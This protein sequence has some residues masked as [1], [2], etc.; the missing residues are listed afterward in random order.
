MWRV[1]FPQIWTLD[2]ILQVG[3]MKD[4]E[5]GKVEILE[6]DAGGVLTCRCVQGG[7][8]GRDK[9]EGATVIQARCGAGWGSR[10]KLTCPV[11]IAE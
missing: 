4:S 2:F 5:L 10:K 1:L 9:E 8:Q 7:E 11:K 3:N 6:R